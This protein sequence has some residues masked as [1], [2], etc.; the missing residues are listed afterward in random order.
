MIFLKIFENFKLS[1]AEDLQYG[2]TTLQIL[3]FR[4]K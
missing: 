2:Y 1:N 4:R 3:L